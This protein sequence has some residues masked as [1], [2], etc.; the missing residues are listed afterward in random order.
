MGT[1]RPAIALPLALA[2]AV[3][4]SIATAGNEAYRTDLEH[5]SG[6][7]FG[8]GAHVS[9]AFARRNRGTDSD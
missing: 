7:D 5:M 1:M 2:V 9:P 6:F 4:T 3:L 8:T